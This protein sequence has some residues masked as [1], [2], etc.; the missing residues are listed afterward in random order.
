MTWALA[1][2]FAACYAS[3]ALWLCRDWA[4]FRDDIAAAAYP[5]TVHP[6]CVCVGVAA[7]LVVVPFLVPFI[8]FGV[9]ADR[10]RERSR[11]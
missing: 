9:V 1:I 2:Y 10:C 11:P 5:M 3:A 8:L 6:L 4:S 7:W